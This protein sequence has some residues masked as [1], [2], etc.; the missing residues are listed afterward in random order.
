MTG[1]PA[2]GKGFAALVDTSLLV[3]STLPRDA[4]DKEHGNSAL[5]TL[6]VLHSR[7]P[8]IKQS[9]I[10]FDSPDNISLRP[11]T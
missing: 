6:E 4:N 10:F 1:Q 5:I 2:L 7:V 9:R 11:I 3:S 8:G